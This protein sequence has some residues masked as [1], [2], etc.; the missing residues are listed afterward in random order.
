MAVRGGSLLLDFN[1]AHSPHDAEQAEAA[2]RGGTLPYMA[3]EQLEAFLDPQ[4]WEDVDGRADLY[5]LGLLLIELLTGRRPEGPDP[6]LPLPRAIRDLLDRREGEVSDLGLGKQ[7][8]SA[9]LGAIARHCTAH[10]PQDRYAQASELAE[11]LRRFVDRRP[12]RYAPNPSRRELARNWAFRHRRPLAVAAAL[13]GLSAAGYRLA[14][15]SDSGADTFRW[16]PDLVGTRPPSGFPDVRAAAHV[17]PDSP[18]RVARKVV[19]SVDALHRDDRF[20]EARPE[21]DRVRS[22]EPA[23]DGAVDAIRPGRG[24]S[25]SRVGTTSRT[26]QPSTGP[27]MQKGRAEFR[28]AKADFE[29][30][31]RLDPDL[32]D[33]LD[34]LATSFH[35]LED[36]EASERFYGEAIAEAEPDYRPKIRGRFARTFLGGGDRLLEANVP[37]LLVAASKSIAAA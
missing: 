14:R 13:L 25:A 26:G 22:L 21:L 28:K 27:T 34:G 35:E 1:L 32:C 18:E 5:A 11:D 10:R 20:D 9:S 8:V 33:A 29:V 23:D 6:E 30:A 3:P 15:Q 12:L 36:Y 37:D 17:L 19:G 31:L 7:A 2:L 16:A 4:R 24:S